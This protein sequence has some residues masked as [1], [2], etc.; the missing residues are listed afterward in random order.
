MTNEQI[1]QVEERYSI[2]FT[3]EHLEFLRIMHTIDRKARTYAYYGE[4]ESECYEHS[5][6]RNWLEDHEEIVT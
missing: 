6:F 5:I 1:D 4:E 3:P 2:R